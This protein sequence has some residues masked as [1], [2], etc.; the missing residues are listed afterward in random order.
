MTS[1]VFKGNEAVVMDERL[2]YDLIKE[3]WSR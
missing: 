3:N 2:L 1:S